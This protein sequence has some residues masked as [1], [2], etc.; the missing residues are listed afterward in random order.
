MTTATVCKSCVAG[1]GGFAATLAAA[2]A[3][4]NLPVTVQ[5][6]DC[7][8]GCKRASTLAFRAPSKMAYLFGEITAADLPD[9]LIFT[10]LYL[11][12][13]DGTLADARPIGDLRFKAIAR[14]PA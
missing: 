9:I 13:P 4:E 8:S 11:A 3:A 7:M 12:A 6:T 14:I 5:E 1:Q 2:F 10:R